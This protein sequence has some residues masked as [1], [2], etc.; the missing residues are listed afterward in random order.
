[1]RRTLC[2]VL[3]EERGTEMYSMAW[4]IERVLW[5]LDENNV[6]GE[7][8]LAENEDGNVI[9]HTIVRIDQDDTGHDIGVFSTTYVDPDFR[10]SG[11][12]AR[13]LERGETWMRDHNMTEAVTYTDVDNVKL[14]NLYITHGYVMSEMSE[15][16]VK[17]AKFIDG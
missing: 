15:Q 11:I 17:L 3:G 5:R 7:V 16:F 1:M 6:V 9:G 2:E 12:A 13:L 10:R 8:F 4:L 14:Q